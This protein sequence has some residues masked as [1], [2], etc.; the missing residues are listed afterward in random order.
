MAI[1]YNALT[2]L[3]EVHAVGMYGKTGA[4]YAELL[5]ISDKIDIIQSTMAKGI[6]IIGGYITGEKNIGSVAKLNL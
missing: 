2:F 6:G 4:G 3:D 1:K 5:G